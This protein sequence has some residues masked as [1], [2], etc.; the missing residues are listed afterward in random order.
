MRLYQMK[1]NLRSTTEEGIKYAVL[2]RTIYHSLLCPMSVLH[3]AYRSGD[4][5]QPPGS[6][7]LNA[8]FAQELIGMGD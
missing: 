4:D 5:R 7:N 3:V 2:L 1:M 8:E 6:V